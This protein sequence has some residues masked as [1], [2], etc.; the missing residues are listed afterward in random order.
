M[1]LRLARE[2][3]DV[4]GGVSRRV[5]IASGLLMLLIGSGLAVLLVSVQ[6]LRKSEEQARHSEAVLASAN[7]VERL[8]VDL[9]DGQRGFVITRD[10]RFLKPW[11]AARSILPEQTSALERLAADDP[12]QR[13][14][15]ADISRDVASYLRDSATLVEA[16]RRDPTSARAE[17]ATAAAGERRIDRLRT[18]FDDM[19]AAE[20]TLSVTQQARSDTAAER[21]V[22]AAA[23][24]LV[25]SLLLILGFTAYLARAV[26][27]PVLVT[28]SMAK[29]LAGGD[30]AAR[31]PETGVGE[32]G[33][34]ERTFN[35]KT[36]EL[37]AYCRGS[38]VSG[39][40]PLS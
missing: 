33:T 37:A 9:E 31:V 5:A 27:R 24:G 7:Q 2:R 29:R 11:K 18:L 40:L 32:I 12:V 21:A 13:D 39:K 30:L 1:T 25:G 15:A 14:R 17:A 16:A 10:E 23:V 8:V 35:S 3:G 26:V 4:I 6:D 28:A 19:I 34:L 20:E 22:I 36:S 38:V